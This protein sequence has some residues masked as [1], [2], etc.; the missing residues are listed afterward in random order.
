MVVIIALMVVAVAS[1]MACYVLALKW[2]MNPILWLLMGLLFGP[3]A[4]A[5]ALISTPSKVKPED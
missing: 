1:A 3:F 2:R 5:A 4:I